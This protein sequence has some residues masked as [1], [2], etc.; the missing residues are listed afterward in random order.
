MA[1]DVVLEI[2]LPVHNEGE[3]IAATV[4]EIYS[5]VAS[6]VP[7]RFIICE[8]GSRDSTVPVLQSLAA[9]FPMKLLTSEA[10]KGYSRAVMDGIAQLEARYVLCLDSDGQCDPADF[11]RLWS[12]RNQADVVIG[13]RVR[14]ADG[15]MRR[16]F[17][18]GFRLLYRRLTGVGVHDPSCPFV[19]TTREA[20]LNVLPRLG[21]MPQG[22]WWEFI[23]RVHAE[24]LKLAEIP[25]N[26]RRRTAGV[27]QVYGWRR[28]P[29]IGWTHLRALFRIARQSGAPQRERLPVTVSPIGKPGA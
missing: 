2:V 6:S 10:R 19:L 9:Q 20:A 7:C 22:F 13:W 15:L 26:H 21:E 14:R 3:S 23:A 28:L 17:S 1:A 29:G 12:A 27:T 11:P 5:C 18:R 4:R 8:D 16:I 25:V 24:G